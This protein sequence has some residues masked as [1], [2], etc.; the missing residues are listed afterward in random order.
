M[1]NSV[2]IDDDMEKEIGWRP[3]VHSKAFGKTDLDRLQTNDGDH[4]QI[5]LQ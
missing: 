1:R 3:T 2:M 4:K 5:S